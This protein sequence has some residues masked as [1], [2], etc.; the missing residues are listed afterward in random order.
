MTRF[1]AFFATARLAAL[2]ARAG[3]IKAAQRIIDAA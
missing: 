3:D 2:A 1:F